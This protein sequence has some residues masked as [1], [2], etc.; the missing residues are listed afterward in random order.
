VTRHVVVVTGAASGIG[1][2]LA[3]QLSRDWTI[4]AADLPA[5]QHELRQ[6]ADA[7]ALHA[8][9]TDV[10]DPQQVE[11]LFAEACRLGTLTGSVNCA[12]V[13]RVAHLTETSPELYDSLMAVNL[14]G[15][16]LMLRAAARALRS[17][18]LPG[19][20]V[21]ISSINAVAGLPD[22]AVYTAAKAAVNSLVTAAAV[23][24]GPYGIRVN[25]IA[26]GS[27]RTAGMNPR[28]GDDPAAVM[29]I[30]MRRV[31]YPNDI[32]GPTRFLLS[33]ESAYVT[34]SVLTVDGGLMHVRGSYH[35]RPADRSDAEGGQET[36]G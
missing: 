29:M 13:T 4:V 36:T 5:R 7:H 17:Q 19:S 6:L 35:P 30:P 1:Q 10:S 21:A 26:P 2:E 22:Q 28:A 15:N 31:G 32:V 12:G 20:I 24:C 27:T 9:P 23:E 16:F 25:A 33:E 3:V 8:V 14:K 18:Q 11:A 34:G